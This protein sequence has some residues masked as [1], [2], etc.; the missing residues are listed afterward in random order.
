MSTKQIQNRLESLTRKWWFFLLFFILFFIVPSY[1]SKPIDPRETSRLV[2]EVLPRA[3]IYSYPAIWP[4]FKILPILLI[5]AIILWGDRATR[6]FSIYVAVTLLAMAILQ[7]MAFTEHYGFAVI[8]GNVVIIS[9]VA[10]FWVWEAV[11][12]ETDMSPQGRPWWRYWVVPPAFLAFWFPVSIGADG[13]RPDWNPLLILT[14]E[15]GLTF[16]MMVP[17]YLAVMTLYHPRINRPVVRLTG[18]VGTVIGLLNIVMWLIVNRETMWWMG[19]LHLP[20]LAISIYALVISL[21]KAAQ[22]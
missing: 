19:V 16:C 9:I 3:L 18:F 7:N 21:R 2:A 13:V 20:Q 8:T 17:V 11:I 12:K 14:S 4:L 1:S 15:A 6:A 10:L 22:D 5:L